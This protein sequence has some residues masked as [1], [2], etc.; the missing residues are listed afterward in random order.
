MT[1]ENADRVTYARF[2]P[3]CA[4]CGDDEHAYQAGICAPCWNVF[5]VGA[6]SRQAEV[7]ELK[8]AKSALL[9]D[10]ARWQG[11][12]EAAAAVLVGVAELIEAVADIPEAWIDAVCSPL[13]LAREGSDCTCDRGAQ[14]EGLK[15][16]AKQAL[17]KIE[18]LGRNE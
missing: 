15:L 8:A 13:C 3:W 6:A 1:A 9:V 11:R 2:S 17:A 16:S 10:G 12:A 5:Q 7:D 18:A 4:F 14:L